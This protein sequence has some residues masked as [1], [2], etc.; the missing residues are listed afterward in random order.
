M[1]NDQSHWIDGYDAGLTDARSA[2]GTVFQWAGAQH[3]LPAGITERNEW[4]H[5]YATGFQ[6]RILIPQEEVEV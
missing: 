5:G 6:L 4:L 1:A 3:T 2:M